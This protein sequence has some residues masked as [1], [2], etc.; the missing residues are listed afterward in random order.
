MPVVPAPVH[1]AAGDHID[2]GDLLF[3]DGCLCCAELGVR[4]IAFRELPQSD[5]Q[6]Q[7]LI[8]ARDTVRADD[9][10]CVRSAALVSDF[11]APHR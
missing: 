9:R 6:V 1:F 2:P 7:R 3:E 10:G 8:P 11:S 5:E 4:E